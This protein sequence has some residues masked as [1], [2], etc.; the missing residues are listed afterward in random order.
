MPSA[1]KG[2]TWPKRLPRPGPLGSKVSKLW[3]SSMRPISGAMR[4][5][6]VRTPEGR[7]PGEGSRGGAAGGANWLRS[8]TPLHGSRLQA[9]PADGEF[10]QRPDDRG[11]NQPDQ[12]GEAVDVDRADRQERRR[13][14]AE[15]EVA[16]GAGRLAQ[17]EDEGEDEEGLDRLL[18][19]ALGEVGGDHIGEA[20][21]QGAG[22]AGC[23]LQ[24]R[25]GG[26]GRER[27]EDRHSDAEAAEA[28]DE[29]DAQALVEGDDDRVGPERVALVQQLPSLTMGQAVGGQQVLG[30]VR[31]EAGAEDPEVAFDRERERGRQQR[32]QR[33][34]PARAQRLP[35]ALHPS[36]EIGDGCH[37]EQRHDDR[38]DD[39]V[40]AEPHR[41]PAERAEQRQ[42]DRWREPR[43]APGAAESD[44]RLT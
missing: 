6:K 24:A 30:H 16:P 33:D 15:G 43:P 2:E 29:A 36:P 28:L 38:S 23:R 18:E 17:G 9:Q 40:A 31:V 41:P 7:G 35:H 37:H 13:D 3:K 25:E 8:R 34:R 12:A 27:R 11:A 21:D 44:R 1:S 22:G 10:Q 39:T 26:Q 4:T 20:D 5:K 19:G 14:E 32:D 42:A